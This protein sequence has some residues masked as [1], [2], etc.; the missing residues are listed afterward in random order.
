MVKES[1]MNNVD[2]FNKWYD[3]LN[4]ILSADG[5]ELAKHIEEDG[6]V[7]GIDFKKDGFDKVWSCSNFDP[8][9]ELKLPCAVTSATIINNMYNEF[10]VE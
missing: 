8:E 5:F 1:N 10:K 2:L 6:A 3:E 7:L 9:A 4:N